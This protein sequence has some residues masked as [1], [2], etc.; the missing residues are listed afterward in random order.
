MHFPFASIYR[1]HAA[2][3]LKSGII[4]RTHPNSCPYTIVCPSIILIS[5]RT[6]CIQMWLTPNVHLIY[7][8][9]NPFS[10]RKIHVVRKQIDKST[11]Q[12]ETNI[13][14]FS[15]ECGKKSEFHPLQAMF[16]WYPLAIWKFAMGAMNHIVRWFTYI[17]K[18]YPIAM[19]QITRKYPLFF[20][21][22]PLYPHYINMKS[23]KSPFITIFCK[24]SPLNHY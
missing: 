22:I 7:Y 5:W 3:Y 12:R 1:N 21:N 16:S 6:K 11:K 2:S 9:F 18:Y 19:S 8:Q 4:N 17:E 24:E 14:M 23:R 10:L 15:G 13:E 20:L